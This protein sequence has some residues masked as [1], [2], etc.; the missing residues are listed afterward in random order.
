M[1]KLLSLLLVSGLLL[2]STIVYSEETWTHCA[3][4]YGLGEPRSCEW[5]D[6]RTVRIGNGS[7]WVYLNKFGGL[8]AYECKRGN[9]PDPDFKWL[10]GPYR[11]EYSSKT[12]TKEVAKPHFCASRNDCSG[13][14]KEL[15]AGAPAKTEAR[16]KDTRAEI[17]PDPHTGAFRT[18]CD[19]S[20]FA[21]DDP[22]VYPNQSGRS[23]LHMFLG[24][25]SVNAHSDTTSLSEVGGST[26]S[27]GILNRSAYWVP[28]MIDTQTRKP[29]LPVFSMIYYK[30][31]Y[32]GL[33]KKGF[34]NLPKGLGMIGREYEWTCSSHTSVKYDHIP[35]CEKGE[36]ILMQVEFPQCWDGK[37][38]WVVGSSHVVNPVKEECPDTHPVHLPRITF[39][40]KYLVEYEGQT[41]HFALSSDMMQPSGSSAHGDW[42]NGWDA[43]TSSKFIENCLNDL[44]DCHANLLGDGTKLY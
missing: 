35:H 3:N 41:D 4:E 37:N 39:N 42:V 24:N 34:V 11:C 44:N 5:N 38:L 33:A 17:N 20:H 30:G 15:P 36:E 29:V 1:R 23:H 43:A 27:G 26:C 32:Q 9:F 14:H 13:I 25:T 10:G 31:G 16:V 6:L 40:I 22:L 19:F 8:P 21:Y 7:Q 12:I 28:A 2:T 18:N